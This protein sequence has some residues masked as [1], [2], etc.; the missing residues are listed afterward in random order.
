MHVA[1]TPEGTQRQQA[2]LSVRVRV[3]NTGTRSARLAR[4]TL[5]AAGVSVRADG[6]GGGA[7]GA[8]GAGET[9]ALTLR[10]ETTGALTARL[11][12]QGSGRLRIAGRALTLTAKVSS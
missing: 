9:R 8:V 6:A 12:N 11:A 7:V 1:T 5:S 4:P 10:F 2:R 3:E